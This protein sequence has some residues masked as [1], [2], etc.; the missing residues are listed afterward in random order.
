MG[1]NV[2]TELNSTVGQ[3]Q[4]LFS[5]IE[6]MGGGNNS[7]IGIN[8]IF[9]IQNSIEQ[10]QS[11]DSQARANGITNLVDKA[12][13]FYDDTNFYEEVRECDFRENEMGIS[14]EKLIMTLLWSN[15]TIE[16]FNNPCSYLRKRIAFFDLGCF[17]KY[18]ESSSLPY[19]NPD[20]CAA[21]PSARFP[22][23]VL[24]HRQGLWVLPV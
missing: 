10:I 12:L 17:E 16:D 2:S 5:Q 23:P 24:S 3:L 4:G 1:F 8:S 9:S 14:K 15:A 11:D 18:Q 13:K 20:D 7:G 21:Q 22:L 19:R 6:S